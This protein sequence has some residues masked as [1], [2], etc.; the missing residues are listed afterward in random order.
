M[1][2]DNR[3]FEGLVKDLRELMDDLK[4]L[5]DFG[6]ISERQREITTL[7]IGSISD[8]ESIRL[9]EEAPVN[10]E[11]IITDAASTRAISLRDE[12][13]VSA[14]RTRDVITAQ[15]WVR[16]EYNAPRGLLPTLSKITPGRQA[17]KVFSLEEEGWVVVSVLVEKNQISSKTGELADVG[18][19]DISAI[20]ISAP[21]AT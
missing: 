1:I 5:T 9:L 7:D 15:E 3:R 17:P 18:A 8:Q 13:P 14:S 16:S 19:V 11:S 2:K 6:G 21:K 20:D 10:E 12:D 4:S